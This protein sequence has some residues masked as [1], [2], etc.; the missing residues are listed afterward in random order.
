MMSN[1]KFQVWECKVVVP[2][3]ELPNGFDAPPRRAVIE[4]IEAAGV[5]V[6]GCNSGWGGSLTDVEKQAFDEQT[7]TV[8]F[9]GVM[10]SDDSA[11]H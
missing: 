4:A 10:D 7:G 1:K 3:G 9:A 2:A 6:W 5:E 11:K 8:Y